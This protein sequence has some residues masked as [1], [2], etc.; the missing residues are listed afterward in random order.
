MW[1]GTGRAELGF[2]A[3]PE[4]EPRWKSV[5]LEDAGD[6]EPRRARSLAAGN[7]PTGRSSKPPTHVLGVSGRSESSLDLLDRAVMSRGGAVR[8]ARG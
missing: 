8:F 2:C 4:R 3:N 1:E 7:Q 6:L 5:S